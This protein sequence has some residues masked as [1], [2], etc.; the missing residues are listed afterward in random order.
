MHLGRPPDEAKEEVLGAPA[1]LAWAVGV[2]LA[3]RL[4]EELDA[5]N[6]GCPVMSSKLARRSSTSDVFSRLG[7]EVFTVRFCAVLVGVFC[8]DLEGAETLPIPE[9]EAACRTTCGL[10]GLQTL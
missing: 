7:V 5:P 3:A 1:C 9:K 8:D 2:E 10:P 4:L 6:G